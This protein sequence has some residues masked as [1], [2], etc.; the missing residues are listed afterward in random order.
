MSDATTIRSQWQGWEVNFAPGFPSESLLPRELLAAAAAKQLAGP[1]RSFLQ[2]GDEQGPPE[3][4]E[5]LAEL[6]NSEGGVDAASKDLLV[7]SGASQALDTLLTLQ[8]TPGDRVLVAEPTYFL[9]LEL[10]KDHGLEVVP[11]ATD[12]EGPLPG[13]LREELKAG[14]RALLY[15]VP[16]FS[17]PTGATL[18]QE[19]A[20]QLVEEADSRGAL[21]V[22]DEVYRLLQFEGEPPASLTTLGA[23][24]V[25]SVNSFSKILAPGMRLGWLQG[26]PKLIE[27]VRT[28][29]L[30]RSGG[31]L[32][33][34]AAHV[35]SALLHSGELAEHIRRLR[36]EYGKRA[37]VLASSL[38][39]EAPALSFTQPAGG[40]F[41]WAQLADAD[42]HALQQAAHH[43]GVDY[44][45]GTAFSPRGYFGDHLR[46]SFSYHPA[47][48]LMEGATRLG[49]AVSKL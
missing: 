37:S 7:T 27:R 36:R 3:F 19:R 43:E 35:V 12:A 15:L 17:N 14:P 4:L 16:S 24:N 42:P 45:P 10:F 21:V 28:S 13:A 6:L 29:G 41:I 34:F 25:V 32:N 5:L 31:G 47:A 18:S 11:L 39:K 40:F 38:Q 8:L 26:S 33:P 30:L 22:A 46:L 23:D 2:Y 49:R 20:R 44:M 1:D 9:A 48:E